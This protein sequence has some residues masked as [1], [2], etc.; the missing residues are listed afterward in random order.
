MLLEDR[1]V[2]KAAF[3]RLQDD[4]VAAIHMSSDD[5]LRCRCLFRDNG[6]GQ[7]YRLAHLFH[8][9]KV[10]G[11]GMPLE[12]VKYTLK[13]VFLER[14]IHYSKNSVLRTLKHG[15]RIPVPDSYLLVGVADEGPA[16]EAQGYTNVFTLKAGEIFGT[17]VRF[18]CVIV[19]LIC[20][21]PAACAQGPD[22]PEPIYIEGMCA[23]VL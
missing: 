14:L 17:R 7:S 6:L 21:V 13:N 3:V 9:L 19:V 4:A 11:M 23:R 12:R 16:Y 5:I 10:I 15:A 20:V 1:G 22:D 2:D 18:V 8:F